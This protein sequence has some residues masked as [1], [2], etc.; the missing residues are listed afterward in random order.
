MRLT[1]V[2]SMCPFGC[3]T[4]TVSVKSP[5]PWMR[6]TSVIGASVLRYS[7]NSAMPPS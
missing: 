7:T 6:H 1:S 3:S 5:E 2:A 4:G